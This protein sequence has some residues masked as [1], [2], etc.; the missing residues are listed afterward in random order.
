MSDIQSTQFKLKI[1]K[2]LLIYIW[3]SVPIILQHALSILYTFIFNTRISKLMISP[4]CNYHKFDQNYLDNYIPDSGAIAYLNFQD[5]FSRALAVKKIIDC[6][7]CWPCDGLLCDY[8]KLDSLPKVSLKKQL[9][10][11]RLVF[12]QSGET[13]PSNY[14]FSNVFL[15]N[16]DYHRIH[17]PVSGRIASIEKIPGGLAVLRPWLYEE[18][19]SL[20]ALIN[21]RVILEILTAEGNKWFL[22]IV[23]GPA[24]KTIQLNPRCKIGKKFTIGEELATFLLGSTCCI[25]SPI[26]QN[27]V[28]IQSKVQFGWYFG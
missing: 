4:Y 3:G 20:P 19:P 2:A 27:K 22:S 13:I 15:H 11:L 10:P 17:S 16:R 23:G 5:F 25:A 21:E 26:S 28:K 24:V 9:L 7:H 14:Y 6:L 8:G 1:T 12:G 18:N